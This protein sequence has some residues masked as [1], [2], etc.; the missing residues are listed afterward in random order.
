MKKNSTQQDT[1]P[2]SG[3]LE[4]VMQVFCNASMG[5]MLFPGV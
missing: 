5:F 3:E 2:G 4:N 1:A